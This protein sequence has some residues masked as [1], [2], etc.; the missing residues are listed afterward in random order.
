MDISNLMAI[1]L[2]L[3]AALSYQPNHSPAEPV[4]KRP[5]SLVITFTAP[6]IDGV[7]RVSALYDSIARV[8][9]KEDIVQA[10]DDSGSLW[11]LT[12]NMSAVQFAVFS[13]SDFSQT[14][15]KIIRLIDRLAD[16]ID[17]IKTAEIKS[18]ASLILGSGC[19][20]YDK[21]VSFY[22]NPQDP[23]FEHDLQQAATR[24]AP[25]YQNDQKTQL[26]EKMVSDNEPF[27]AQIL[28]WKD[29]RFESY[30]SAGYIAREFKRQSTD[31]SRF[32]TEILF[33]D[34]CLCLLLIITG[35]KADLYSDHRDFFKFAKNSFNV[36]ESNSWSDYISIAKAIFDHDIKDFR[37]K[38]MKTAWMKHFGTQI[39]D[40]TFESS[41]IPPS[42][43]RLIQNMPEKTMHNFSYS[44]DTNPSVVAFLHDTEPGLSEIAV[45][46]ESSYTE[47]LYEGLLS[48][49][50][51]GFAPSIK[52]SCKN[53][54]MVQ[55][56]TN[57]S[58]IASSLSGLRAAILSILAQNN[59]ASYKDI[60]VN[61][62][63]C[64]DVAPFILMGDIKLGWPTESYNRQFSK[65]QI[66]D[67]A[68]LIRVPSDN[69]KGI[70]ARWSI[71]T[72]TP[73]SSSVVLAQLISSGYYLK[74]LVLSE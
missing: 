7:N 6:R 65:A 44:M 56:S 18:D 19:F 5:A 26:T 74:N 28:H 13:R 70:R 54:I 48:Y 32:S 17:F 39:N 64:S 53:N 72:S 67:L 42:Q 63:A 71:L 31:A 43:K 69:H 46:I 47:S 2:A 8:L 61:I 24:L 60:M 27:I 9:K 34:N 49:K 50:F 59:Q 73:K 1:F 23:Q 21:P 10:I 45:N 16:D 15:T 55:F 51:S 36:P 20:Y 4:L 41:Y 33:S 62:A 52:M 14:K 57:N 58:M 12:A 35:T 66:E 29:V 37:K 22:I 68:S 11:S 25:L 40:Y 3:T 38:A 30:V